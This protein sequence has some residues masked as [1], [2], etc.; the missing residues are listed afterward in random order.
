M[1]HFGYAVNIPEGR[2]EKEDD[3]IPPANELA[4]IL[5]SHFNEVNQSGLR[6]K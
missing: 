3:A 1:P 2:K 6:R 4:G 5:A